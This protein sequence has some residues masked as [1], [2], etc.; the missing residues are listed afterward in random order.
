M[1]TPSFFAKHG[2][3]SLGELADLC[4][5]TL[6]EDADPDLTIS[7]V[8]A[9]ADAAPGSIVYASTGAFLDRLRETRASACIVTQALSARAET[10]AALVIHDK[11]EAAFARIAEAFY[12]E[13]ARTPFAIARDTDAMAAGSVHPDARIEDDV[14]VEPGAVVGADAEIG[15]GTRILAGTVI[16]HSVRIGRDCVIGPNAT[17]THALIG[18][19]VILHAGVSV[20]QDGFGYYST[21]EGHVKIVQVGRVIIQDDVEIGATTTVDR[22]ALSDTVIGEG[23]KID[24]QVQI[25]HNVVIGRHC[26]IV[27]HVAIGGSARIGDFVAI[28]GKA[29]L[30]EHVSVVSGA[31]IAGTTTVARDIQTA[32]EWGGSPVAQPM[33]DWVREYTVIKRLVRA[34]VEKGK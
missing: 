19:R 6:G 26:I 34:A 28:G 1:T 4:G 12:P 31:R 21:A 32:G 17:V 22:G 27:A 5:G 15:R 29:V 13:A 33:Q 11:P 7:D 9:I 3:F 14:V 23:T 8:A 2:P 25:A 24:N 20:G 18:D 10:A 16:G 30:R